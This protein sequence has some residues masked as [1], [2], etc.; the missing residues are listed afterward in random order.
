MSARADRARTV[1]LML[2]AAAAITGIAA[3]AFFTGALDVGLDGETRQMLGGLLGVATVMD[4]VMARVMY[5]KLSAK[6]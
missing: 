4:L 3:A 6:K 5:Q 2:V 1:A